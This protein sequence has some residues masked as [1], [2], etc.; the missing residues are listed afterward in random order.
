MVYSLLL[1]TAL[2]CVIGYIE[3]IESLSDG[4][5]TDTHFRKALVLAKEQPAQ[6]RAIVRGQR[7]LSTNA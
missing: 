4:E 6:A 5:N 2:S 3:E 1:S 7:T